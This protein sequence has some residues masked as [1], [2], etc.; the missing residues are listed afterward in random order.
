M[1]EKYRDGLHMW[2]FCCNFVADF[3][4]IRPIHDV[5][6][7]RGEASERNEIYSYN[8]GNIAKRGCY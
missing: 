2:I 4:R 7:D 8:R 6:R 3:K 5:K 1:E